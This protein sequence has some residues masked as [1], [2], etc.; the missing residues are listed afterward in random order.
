MLLVI[1][2]IS[3]LFFFNSLLVG[4]IRLKQFV[5]FDFFCLI[6]FLWDQ[7][8]VYLLIIDNKKRQSVD[9]FIYLFFFMVFVQFLKFNEIFNTEINCKDYCQVIVV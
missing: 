2:K 1:F 8:S 6:F 3:F 7:F 4:F 5:I 9:S